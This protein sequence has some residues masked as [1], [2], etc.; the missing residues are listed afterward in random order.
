MLILNG[1]KD[2][3]VMAGKMMIHILF[4]QESTQVRE[5][6]AVV[7][8]VV[9]DTIVLAAR[10][11]SVVQENTVLPRQHHVTPVLQ[12]T[13]VRAIKRRGPH[14][15]MQGSTKPTQCRVRAILV[16][17]VMLAPQP[18]WLPLTH[19]PMEPIKPVHHNHLVSTALLVRLL[20]HYSQ[21]TQAFSITVKLP[22]PSPL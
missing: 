22:K 6:R 2:V 16:L 8:Y 10:R 21:T 17:K 11:H 1:L 4:L 20:L 9:Q 7:R 12:G 19:V 18:G 3:N 13:S 5:V 15:V 14:L